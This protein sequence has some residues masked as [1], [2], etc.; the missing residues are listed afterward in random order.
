[1]PGLAAQDYSL[2][3]GDHWTDAT[4]CDH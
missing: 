4:F 1:L 3:K 2:D